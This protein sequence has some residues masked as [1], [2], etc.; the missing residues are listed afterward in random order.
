[1]PKVFFPPNDQKVFH[2]ADFIVNNYSSNAFSPWNINMVENQKVMATAAKRNSTN[3]KRS[4]TRTTWRQSFA[5]VSSSFFAVCCETKPRSESEISSSSGPMWV[6]AWGLELIFFDGI[7]T[8]KL[9]NLG[10]GLT[11]DPAN[12]YGSNFFRSG[13]KL[14]FYNVSTRNSLLLTSATRVFQKFEKFCQV[15][16]F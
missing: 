11:L 1:M 12:Y 9:R 4:M 2:L 13:Q 8:W 14:K 7:S 3:N 5:M 10:S 6:R 15:L 16:S